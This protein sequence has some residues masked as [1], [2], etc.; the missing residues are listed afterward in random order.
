MDDAV[1][2]CLSQRF[3][4]VAAM[5]PSHMEE[6]QVVRYRMGEQY[7]PHLDV[8]GEMPKRKKTIFAYLEDLKLRTGKCGGGTKFP[9]IRHNGQSLTVYPE[10]G[11]AVMWD[12][13]S[14]QGRVNPLTLHAGSP[15]TCPGARKA[16]LNVWFG[17]APVHGKEKDGNN[18]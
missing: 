14:E 11:T 7:K 2:Q 3:A 4:T 16:G 13:L 18:N 12:N 6:L 1:M 5:P 10:R 15:I 8:G 9:K 17:E